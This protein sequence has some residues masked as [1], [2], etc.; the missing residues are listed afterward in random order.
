MTVNYS[1]LKKVMKAYIRR[2][3]FYSMVA[4]MVV[5]L[6]SHVITGDFDLFFKNI[7]DIVVFRA[8][9]TIGIV[10]SAL[11]VLRGPEV[12]EIKRLFNNRIDQD[13]IKIAKTFKKIMSGEWE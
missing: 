12:L 7:K 6:L 9:A 10:I 4:F 3:G 1:E 11:I 2:I 5:L 8:L 13:T